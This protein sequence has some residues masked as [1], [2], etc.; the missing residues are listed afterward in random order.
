MRIFFVPFALALVVLG[1][2][3]SCKKTKEEEP[4]SSSSAT[5]EKQA[6]PAIDLMRRKVGLEKQL[7]SIIAKAD[8]SGQTQMKEA[9]AKAR[10]A[11]QHFLTVQ[12]QHPKLQKLFKKA[13]KVSG[14]YSPTDSTQN[15][16]IAAMM[17]EINTE[18]YKISST[19]PELQAARTA[20]VKARKEIHSTRRQLADKIPLAKEILE[21][22]SE[23]DTKL[24]AQRPQS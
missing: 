19:L 24:A 11:D 1:T 16:K 21:E 13:S 7:E 20:Q 5:Q 17:Q 9:E 8:L 22:L 6:H 4:H 2:T 15:A 3:I 12:R 18:I 14:R 23:I 10:E